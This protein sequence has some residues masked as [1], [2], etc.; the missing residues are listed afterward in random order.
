MSQSSSW[1]SESSMYKAFRFVKVRLSQLTPFNLYLISIIMIGLSLLAWSL[2][3][4]PFYESRLNLALLI[5]LTA[6]SALI[7]ASS[8]VSTK[9]GITYQIG[10]V[11]VLAAVPSMGLGAGILI[12]TLLNVT[13]WLVKPADER[14]WKK[15]WSQLAFNNGMHSIALLGAGWVLSLLINW[16]GVDS[17]WGWTV[18]WIC[19]AVLYEEINLWLLI[20]ILRLQHGAEIKVLEVWREDRWASQIGIL[21][22]AIGGATLGFAIQ[23]YN[24]VGIIIFFL[25]IFLSAYAFRLYVGQMQEHLDQL[26]QIVHARTEDLAELHKQK[27]ALLAV[28]THDIITPLTSI[29][30]Y[31]EE[32]KR[33]PE[34]ILAKP[35]LADLMLQSHRTIYGLVRNM[36]DIEKLQSGKVL[37]AQK[38]PVDL[39]LLITQTVEI[40]LPEA[41]R[42][43]LDLTIQ[44]S[45]QSYELVV[46]RLQIERVLYNLLSN[47]I[48]YTPSGGSIVVE[49]TVD[50]TY[51]QFSVR[52]TGYS[53]P[54]E[55]L[56]FIFE[57]YKR[58]EILQDKATGT[59]LGLAITKALV[60]EHD[61]EIQ[62]ES[63]AG[64]GSKFTVTLPIPN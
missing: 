58:V 18:P 2:S 22:L 26:E 21:V 6:I 52:D 39:Q 24:W 25:P 41:A 36:L 3:Q 59:G 38:E 30:L 5:T 19:A 12:S 10:S 34:S 51:F 8:A 1:S 9:A 63:T 61:G 37:S 54:E 45:N 33:Q 31:A 13:M 56:P 27:D 16:L 35:E 42:K 55:E 32:L 46:D 50:S 48:K 60:E 20:G 15:S 14:T 62:V 64:V 11:I 49:T 40:M 43:K 28:L 23:N 53:I 44:T 17:I 47:A 29:Q 4:L 7:T 57:R